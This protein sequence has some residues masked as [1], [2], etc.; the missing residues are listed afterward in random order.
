MLA[1]DA[2]AIINA[3]AEALDYAHGRGLVHRDVKP[4][5]ILRTHPD[6]DGNRRIYLADF[7]IVRQV[8]E[9]TGLTATNAAVRLIHTLHTPAEDDPDHHQHHHL[10]RLRRPPNPRAGHQLHPAREP[11]RRQPGLLPAACRPGR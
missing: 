9:L 7:G 4:A 1:H 8:D 10:A 11:L 5:N 2:L 3:I 6:H